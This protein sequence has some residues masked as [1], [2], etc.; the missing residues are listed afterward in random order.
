MGKKITVDAVV[1]S[2]SI[3]TIIQ[4]TTGHENAI[5]VVMESFEPYIVEQSTVHKGTPREYVDEDLAQAL[6]TTLLEKLPQFRFMKA[7]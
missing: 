4:A 3:D 2:L 1:R 5:A 6:R 7:N